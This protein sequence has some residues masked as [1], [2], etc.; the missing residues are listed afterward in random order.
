MKRSCDIASL[1]DLLVKLVDFLESSEEEII[2]TYMAIR[3][4]GSSII[5]FINY[6]PYVIFEFYVKQA[7]L[8]YFHTFV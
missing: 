5:F 4:P 6:F 2:N 7:R 8:V 3:R 1:V